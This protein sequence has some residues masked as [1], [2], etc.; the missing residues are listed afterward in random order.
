MANVY[1]ARLRG[2]DGF[3]RIIA[4]KMLKGETSHD[5]KFVTMFIDEA[6]ILA[7]L[8]HPNIVQI[9]DLG[10]ANDTIF[11]AMELLFGQSLADVWDECRAQGVRL[12]GDVVAWIGARVAEALDYAHDARAFDGSP[13][14]L[15]HRDVNPSNIFVTYD[16]HIKLIDFGL[17][18]GDDRASKTEFGVVKGKIAYLSPEQ[19]AGKP[20]DRRTDIFSLGA[21]LWEVSADRRLFKRDTD[22]ETLAAIRDAEVPDPTKLIPEYPSLLWLVLRRSLERLPEHRYAT[23]RELARDLDGVARAHGSILQASTIGEIMGT[24]FADERAQEAEWFKRAT[25]PEPPS[26]LPALRPAGQRRRH[27]APGVIPDSTYLV[28]VPTPQ[29]TR[30]P[31]PDQPVLFAPPRPAPILKRLR[32]AAFLAGAALVGG[33]LAALVRTLLR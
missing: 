22:L 6:R 28:P 12:R 21:T 5:Q 24:L 17:V 30:P 8:S 9:Y 14:N 25:A 7:R 26:D 19:L 4:L 11:L 1:A 15:V 32:V 23:A 31:K 18:K 27:A 2:A 16:G 20:A 33:L 29:G 13:Q 3:E 10:R